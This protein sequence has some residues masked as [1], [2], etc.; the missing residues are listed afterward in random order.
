MMGERSM[1]K[2]MKRILGI[3]LGVVMTFCVGITIMHAGEAKLV[4]AQSQNFDFSKGTYSGS[5]T[6]CKITW[7]DSQ[8]TI[9]QEKGSSNNSV[10]QRYIA[11]PRWYQNH[12]VT[13]T[14]AEGV[15]I[16][17]L[18][19]TCNSD[20]Y[21]SEL[22]GSKWT[23]ATSSINGAIVTVTPLLGSSSFKVTLSAQSRIK[24]LSYSYSSQST[25]NLESIALSGSMEKTNYN[26]AESWDPKG[27]VVT[28]TYS[29]S[30]TKDL[31]AGATFT[32]FNA[33]G[34]EVAKPKDLGVGK[35]QT[36]MVSA[37]YDGIS[38]TTKYTVSTMIVVT[39]TVEYELVT[40]PKQ[41]VRGTTFIFVGS[42][43]K[44]VS[45]KAMKQAE[46]KA[47]SASSVAD[48]TLSDSFNK[49]SMAASAD[50]TIFTLDGT[51]GSWKIK[52]G[53][54]Q[55]GFTGGANNDMQF[56]AKQT[57]CFS[58]NLSSTNES[59]Y[60]LAVESK[61][62]S[63]RKLQFN[64]LSPRFS[65]YGGTQQ[66]IYM[67]ANIP[68]VT[69]GTTDHISITNLSR[70]EF[71]VG[72][73]F[74]SN[75][76]AITA[77]DGADESNANAKHVATYATS[78]DGTQFTES[79][80]G[81]K[82]VTVTYNEGEASFTATY[83]VNI[84]ATATYQLVES[85]P[86][87]WSG[88]Y[89]ITSD[90]G[91]A[92][93]NVPTVGTYAMKSSLNTYDVPAN[94][95]LVSKVTDGTIT[96][97]TAGQYLQWSI[98]T[99]STGYSIQGLSG[100]YIGWNNNDDKN[101]LTTSDSPLVNTLSFN[102]GDVSIICSAGTR[103]L[104]LDTTSGRFRYYSNP[105]VKLYKLVESQDVSDYAD[106]F[107]DTLSTGTT[108]VCKPDGATNI[109]ALKSSWKELADLFDMLSNVDKQQF[110]QGTADSSGNNVSQALALYDYIAAKYNTQLQGDGFVAN[111]DFIGRGITALSNAKI[112]DNLNMQVDSSF[113]VILIIL[114]ATFAA[115][116]AYCLVS[117]RK[118]R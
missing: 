77:Y 37:S 117:R 82:S 49:G 80:I 103:G 14:P 79:D 21:A 109:D 44:T 42:D 111:Y 29:D 86:T 81:E 71:A 2:L 90:V 59:E 38:T 55:L 8:I 69:F 57:D 51:T 40:D 104:K 28:G 76:L 31:S 12:I 66:D 50:A 88:T 19:I 3:G 112:S 107:L 63:G 106:I 7:S 34:V 70:T 91:T 43:D 68:E 18:T 113:S 53:D 5:G 72:E 60:K 15:V 115:F 4:S 100:K 67:F 47:D 118:E 33:E 16:E 24:S 99:Y 65:N 61:K 85:E 56:N 45:P 54:N 97:I 10:D 105:S 46:N 26:T 98:A 6:S 83:N 78:L 73:I 92:T 114:I 39:Q 17:N 102:T 27:L 64:S 48:V 87:N 74:T 11:K 95:S 30:T 36:L 52:N 89:L 23:D 25:A 84:Y 22:N 101:G 32:Y 58:I 20:K 96:K 75:G 62:Y 13:F 35:N 116:G 41:L 93:E 94:Y 1:G 110:T 9:V 108:A